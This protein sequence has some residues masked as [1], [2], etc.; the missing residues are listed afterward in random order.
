M[1]ESVEEG[2]FVSWTTEKGRYVGMVSSVRTS[3]EIAV[4]SS[5]GGQ[6][7]VEASAENPVANVRIYVDNE[8]GSYSRSDI[9]YR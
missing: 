2:Q 6:E 7:T 4:V 5:S 1:A 3:G 9:R 8:D